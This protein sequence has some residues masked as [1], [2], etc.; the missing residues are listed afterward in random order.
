MGE[1]SIGPYSSIREEG[2]IINPTIPIKIPYRSKNVAKYIGYTN[3]RYNY[4]TSL[5]DAI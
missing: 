5:L 1:T 4:I 3:K 2:N